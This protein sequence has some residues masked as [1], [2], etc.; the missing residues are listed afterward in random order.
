MRPASQI[1]A[2][3]VALSLIFLF[4]CKSNSTEK[5]PV[6]SVQTAVVQK[7][8]LV[9]TV[10]A[11]A[12]LFP[13]QQAAITPKISAPVH[14][15]FVNRGQRVH[16][17]ELLAQLENRDLAAAAMEN[18]GGYEQAEASYS[19]TTK[20]SLPEEWKKAELDANLA[21]Q[22]LEAE[23][24]LY[25]SRE[26]LYKQGALPR[27]EL[28]SA[29]V[30]LTQARS[31]YEVAQ[32]H[33]NALQAVGKQ[34]QLK[35]ANGQ[36]TAAR[37]KYLGASA[38]LSYSAIRSPIDGVVAERTLYQ[39]E[40]AVAGTPLITIID[41]SQVIAKAHIPQEQA[42]KL[43]VGN[44]ATLTVPGEDQAF[45]GKITVVSPAVDPNS[46]TVEIWVQLANP[47]QQLRPGTSA[48]LS[49]E[50]KKLTDVTLVPTE[51]I[52]TQPDTGAVV[53]V[54][55]KDN[56]AHQTQVKVGAEQGKLAQILEGVNPGETVVTSGAYGLPDGAQVQ[57]QVPEAG[58]SKDSEKSGK[59]E[60]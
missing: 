3:A 17:G 21:K 43:K 25:S 55:G 8:D 4:A 41:A 16:K 29:G 20:S 51:S 39:G 31:Q 59:K 26:V 34:D 9:E 27:K 10:E 49:M 2:A 5:K 12:N 23:Q 30:A 19:T 32:Q 33:L 50:A 58:G 6:V 42:A 37:G 56:I 54:V 7:G 52:V 22:S 47:K 46:T 14:K 35:S 60:D 40:T 36:L 48:H 53:F 13:I 38:Q 15:F 24:K 28:D 45:P 1:G 11:E 44:R 57:V 18:K